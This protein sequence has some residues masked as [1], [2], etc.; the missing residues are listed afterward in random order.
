VNAR[1]STG[2]RGSATEIAALLRMPTYSEWTRIAVYRLARGLFAHAVRRG[3]V[4]RN[5]LDGLG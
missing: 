1:G 4:T 3:L 2:G 5:P